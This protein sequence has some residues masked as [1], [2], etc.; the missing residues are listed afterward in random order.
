MF[1]CARSPVQGIP[2]SIRATTNLYGVGHNWVKGRSIVILLFQSSMS[3]IPRKYIELLIGA[4][5]NHFQLVG[6]CDG[7][8]KEA[9][10]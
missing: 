3:H 9:L 1:S 2:I 8:Q 6:G 4:L 5:V 7:L 10:F